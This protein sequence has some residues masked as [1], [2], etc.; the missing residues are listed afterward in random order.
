VGCEE[1]VG[2]ESEEEP[3]E[4]VDLKREGLNDMM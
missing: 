2:M 4:D 1:R 3:G